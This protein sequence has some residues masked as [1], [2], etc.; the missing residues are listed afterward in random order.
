MNS[1][2]NFPR[3]L[4]KNLLTALG[5]NPVVLLH[6]PRQC[7]KTTLAKE[8][9]SDQ[10]YAYLT[11]DDANQLSFAKSDPMGFVAELPEKVVLDEIQ[12]APELFAPLKVLIDKDRRPGRALLTGSANVLL[13]PKLSDS[14]AGRMEILKLYPL[15]QCER[16]R[17]EPQFLD[18]LLSGRFKHETY[19]RLGIELASRV[20]AGGFPSAL[21]RSDDHRRGEWYRNYA[22]TLIQRDVKEIARI[23]TLE[24]L[25]KLLNLA[26][27]QTSRLFNVSGL[28][29]PFQLSQPTIRE[30]THLLERI[31]LLEFLP[32]WYNNRLKRSIK[33]PKLHL[34]DSGLAAALLRVDTK[35]LGKDRELLGQLVETFIFQ[36]L[37]RHATWRKDALTFHHYRDRDVDEVDIVIES[38]A[39]SVAGVEIKSSSTVTHSDFR[40][41]KKL[42]AAAGKKFLAGVVLYDGETTFRLDESLYAVPIAALWE[43]PGPK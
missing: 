26:V 1:P 37:R 15:A 9:A 8:I 25:P 16:Q 19:R 4:K 38:G 10:G 34:V 28:A 3:Y 7:G 42:K 13:A 31:F 40:G 12:K 20:V 23:H 17:M 30:Y 36:E 21:A 29:A 5:D 39:H 27:G 32:A 11:F 2:P 24:A 14:L 41:L 6:G 43:K 22:E 33:S 35:A 18:Q